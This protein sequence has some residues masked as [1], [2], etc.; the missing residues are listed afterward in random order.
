MENKPI[1]VTG[2]TGTYCG[3]EEFY[4]GQLISAPLAPQT[5]TFCLDGPEEIIKLSK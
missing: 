2:G 4:D 3:D 1:Q 5:I